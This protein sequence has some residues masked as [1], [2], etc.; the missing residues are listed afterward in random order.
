MLKRDKRIQEMA[1]FLKLNNACSIKELSNKFNVSEMT[2]RR[3]LY[4]LESR[5]I[6]RFIHGGAVF[7]PE[8][9]P[10][11][12]GEQKPQ[13]Y[14]GSNYL[15]NQQ[16]VKN[17]EEK[18]A[19][20]KKAAT[21]IE[22]DETVMIDS[23]TTMSYL[24]RE[25]DNNFPFTAICWSLNVLVELSKKPNCRLISYGGYFHAETVMFENPYPSE[26]VKY[27][28]ASKVFI[29]AGGIHPDLGITCPKSY[30]S[31]TK[32]IALQSSKTSILLVDSSKFGKI[33]STHFA[34]LEDF[35]II[36]TDTKV[37]ETLHDAVISR[38]V[39]LIVAQ[40][41]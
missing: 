15:F 32:Q 34:N 20:A 25:I 26:F 27:T 41:P 30:E 39:Q 12:A 4:I 5:K 11:L 17:K 13:Q 9:D 18:T 14:Y 19:I 21:L 8:Y 6:V 1:L 7:N 23:G 10:Q 36:I 29:S 28:R 37:D 31:G 22:P 38:G 2:V 3:D 24:C 33:A 16:I 40:L 35:D